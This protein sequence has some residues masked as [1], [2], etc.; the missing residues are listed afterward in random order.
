MF[1]KVHIFHFTHETRNSWD[2]FCNKKLS[3]SHCS[4]I[5]YNAEVPEK[6]INIVI[7]ICCFRSISSINSKYSF[8]HVLSMFETKECLPFSVLSSDYP[9]C[10][11]CLMRYPPVPDIGYLIEKAQYLR[12]PNVGVSW[13]SQFTGI[14]YVNALKINMKK[15]QCL[16]WS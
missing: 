13:S 5:L 6:L 15:M 14:Y 8:V 7:N 12:E 11:T 1:Q 16:W 2:F 9:Q 3:Y 4:N 10:L